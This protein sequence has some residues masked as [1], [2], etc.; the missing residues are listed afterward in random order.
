MAIV[1]CHE[2]GYHHIMFTHTHTTHGTVQA[3]CHHC[4]HERCRLI[5]QWHPH[6]NHKI[7][8]YCHWFDVFTKTWLSSFRRVCQSSLC[9]I[10]PQPLSYD[11]LG[12]RY[13][14]QQSL[15]QP[16]P[17]CPHQTSHPFHHDRLNVTL[18]IAYSICPNLP[19]A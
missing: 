11:A 4:R 3:T 10:L 9:R 17:W 1:H 15:Q 7:F 5:K 12:R 8:V 2:A 14:T 16:M 19:H 13:S 6:R 18:Y